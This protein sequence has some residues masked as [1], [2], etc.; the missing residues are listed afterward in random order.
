MFPME[1]TLN[2]IT[3]G[4]TMV[5]HIDVMFNINKMAVIVTV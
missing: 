4:F 1:S 5:S 3:S 2:N